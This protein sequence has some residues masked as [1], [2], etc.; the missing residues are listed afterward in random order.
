MSEKNYIVITSFFLGKTC[1]WHFINNYIVI[2]SCVV[3]LLIK[4]ILSSCFDKKLD[5]QVCP[6]FRQK[7]FCVARNNLPNC[8][9][10]SQLFV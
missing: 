5:L 6:G 9:G 1:L 2:T 10:F 4:N 7:E 3:I 8:C